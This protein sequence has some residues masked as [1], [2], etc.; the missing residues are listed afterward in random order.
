MVE[1]PAMLDV[2][3]CSSAIPDAAVPTCCVVR[4]GDMAAEE[5]HREGHFCGQRADRRCQRDDVSN[6]EVASEIDEPASGV[7]VYGMVSRSPVFLAQPLVRDSLW[8]VFPGEGWLWKQQNK[9]IS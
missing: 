4:P 2:G 5:R 3:L 1:H 7:V 9:R 6:I 8:C